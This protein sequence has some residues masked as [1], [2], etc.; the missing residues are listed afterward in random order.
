VKQDSYGSCLENYKLETGA[1]VDTKVKLSQEDLYGQLDEFKA[2]F[3]NALRG[4]RGQLDNVE[5]C[6]LG[7]SETSETGNHEPNITNTSH[8]T[9]KRFPTKK[10]SSVAIRTLPPVESE[11]MTHWAN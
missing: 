3:I 6:F 1:S 7:L 9:E 4:L 11:M 8:P 5:L 10:I 2:A